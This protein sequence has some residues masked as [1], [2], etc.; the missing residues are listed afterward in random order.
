MADDIEKRVAQAIAIGGPNPD[1]YGP[2][3]KVTAVI[4]IMLREAAKVAEQGG[5]DWLR[6]TIAADIRALAETG[7]DDDPC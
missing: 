2:K 7:E 3:G 4:A 5:E 1:V 6:K